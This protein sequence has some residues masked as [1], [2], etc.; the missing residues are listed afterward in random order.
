MHVTL[1][2]I[3]FQPPHPP[4]RIPHLQSEPTG[5]LDCPILKYTHLIVRNNKHTTEASHW[6]MQHLDALPSLHNGHTLAPRLCIPSLKLQ[7]TLGALSQEGETVRTNLACEACCLPENTPKI[8]I[9]YSKWWLPSVLSF[10]PYR[11]VYW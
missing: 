8:D 5:L 9:Q 3:Y 7:N 10:F 4:A 1:F 11:T 2:D 6:N